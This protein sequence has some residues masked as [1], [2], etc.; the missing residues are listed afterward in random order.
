[1]KRK[2]CKPTGLDVHPVQAVERGQLA[3][4]SAISTEPGKRRKV[5]GL[6][7]RPDAGEDRRP[8]HVGRAAARPCAPG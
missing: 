7:G 2:A 3:Q 5:T 1:M 6:H 4:R 8:V